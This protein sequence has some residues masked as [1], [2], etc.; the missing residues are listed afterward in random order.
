MAIGLP[1]GYSMPDEME[2]AILLVET[3]WTPEQLDNASEKLINNFL[4]YKA[5]KQVLQ[6][7][8]SLQF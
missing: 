3:G 5:I 4:L 6:N 1:K 7:G 8:G 2:D